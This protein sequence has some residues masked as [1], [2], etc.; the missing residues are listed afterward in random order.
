MNK[1]KSIVEDI[2]KNAID[3]GKN[4]EEIILLTK[5]CLEVSGLYKALEEKKEAEK[6]FR[7][8]QYLYW[9]REHLSHKKNLKE[10]LH[11]FSQVQKDLLELQKLV[12]HDLEE[13]Q[14]SYS[15][16]ETAYEEACDIY[17]KWRQKKDLLN[18]A[19]K[20]VEQL[21]V[22]PERLATFYEQ[23]RDQKKGL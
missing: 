23:Y 16:K 10:K 19:I 4:N 18:D 13:A 12:H 21:N 2:E 22:S 8:H 6:T 11:T 14:R 9:Q 5:K 7:T 1:Y 3:Y 17:S 15:K 20:M